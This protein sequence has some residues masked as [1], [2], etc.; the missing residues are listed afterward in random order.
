MKSDGLFAVLGLIYRCDKRRFVWKGICTVLISLL[1]LANLYVVKLIVDSLSVSNTENSIA[2]GITSVVPLAFLFAGIYLLVRLI[3]VLNSVNDDILAQRLTDSINKEIQDQSV[4][5][6]MAYYDNP[7]FH[8]TFHRAQQ[9]ASHRPLM[10]LNCFMTAFG[11]VIAMGGVFALLCTSSW[12]VVVILLVAFLP[13]FFVRFYKSRRIYHFRKSTTQQTRRSA[14]YGALLS[15]RAPAQEVRTFGLANHFRNLYVEVRANLVAKLISISRRIGIC[16]AATA[17][18]ESAALCAVLFFLM[19]PVAAGIA[20]IGTFVMLFEAFRRGQGYMSSLVSGVSGIYEQRLFVGNLFEFLKLEPNIVSPADPIPFPEK[21]DSVEF[22]NI[23]FSYPGMERQV[24]THFSLKARVGEI[25]HIQGENGFGKSTLLKLLLRLYDPQDGHVRINGRDIREFDLTEL[26]GHIGV[27]F[28][29]YGRY[30]F[31]LRENIEFGN[32]RQPHNDKAF[33]D[34]V[35]LA[36]VEEIANRLPQGYETLLGRQFDGGQELSMGQWQRV[37]LAR[38][39]YSQSP[40]MLMDEPTAWMDKESRERFMS[41]L[42][43]IRTGRI[44]I[45][46]SHRD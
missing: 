13:S 21:I 30:C 34:A 7:E 26:R 17:I 24:L 45:L 11:A 18:A 44:L 3:G 31:T 46:V 22:D 20:S 39:I 10:M 43:E 25:T 1:P 32:I 8:D 38:M 2:E 15:S 35:R 19:Q 27:V 6:D 28:Q 42:E 33:A 36:G 12:Q 23:T 9:E 14:Y 16:D 40:I 41:T 29:D 4:R 5:L 37:A